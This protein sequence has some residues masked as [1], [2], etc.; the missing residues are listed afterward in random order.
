M[1]TLSA[2]AGQVHFDGKDNLISF[3]TYQADGNIYL[4]QTAFAPNASKFESL[5]APAGA[6][7]ISWPRQ[8]ENLQNAVSK[9]PL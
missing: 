7:A 9:L 3:R 2:N 8:A 5:I 4:E 6:K 1:K